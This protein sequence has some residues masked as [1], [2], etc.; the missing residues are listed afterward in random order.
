[1]VR[2]S[3][4]EPAL[5]AYQAGVLPLNYRR[6]AF[7]ARVELAAVDL[8]SRRS[9]NRAAGTWVDR[10]ESNP[11]QLAHNQPAHPCAF[12]QHGRGGRS[13]TCCLVIP[14]ITRPTVGRHLE[15]RKAQESNPRPCG[16]HRL[17][18]GLRATTDSLSIEEGGRVERLRLRVAGFRIRCG[19]TAASPSVG[20]PCRS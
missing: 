1:M 16:P 17:A 14:Q 13:R 3:G 19:T 6:V 9:S 12:D 4:I 5:P 10:R 18:T 15:Q 11:L 8:G 7:R 20:V 2:Q